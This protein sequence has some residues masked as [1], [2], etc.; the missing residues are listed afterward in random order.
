MGYR[1]SLHGLWFRMR[2]HI[3]VLNGIDL[4]DND[5]TVAV[6]ALCCFHFISEK[7]KLQ[8]EL[9]GQPPVFQGDIILNDRTVEYL[10]GVA[11][12]G[13]KSTRVGDGEESTDGT[14]LLQ[15]VYRQGKERRT[16]ASV[17]SDMFKW[18]NATV[19][20]RFDDNFCEL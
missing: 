9:T 6:P 4:C 2:P 18:P 11:Q 3:T 16:R 19:V 14:R 8:S 17:R 20:F 1:H 15:T 7:L 5:I 10:S 13:S 12:H